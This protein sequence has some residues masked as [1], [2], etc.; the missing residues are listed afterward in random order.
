MYAAIAS[1]VPDAAFALFTGDIVDHAIWNTTQAQNTLDIDDA[2]AR[3]QHSGLPF[4]YGTAG[5]HEAHPVNAFPPSQPLAVY[6][7][8]A[9]DWTP[10]IGGAA[11]ATADRTGSYSVV[12]PGG[13][14]KVISVNTNMYYIDNFWM[15]EDPME[16]D[17]NGQFAWLV[18]EL[19]AAEKAGQRVY[20]IGHMPMGLSDAFHDPS[21]YFDQIVRRYEGTIAAMFFGMLIISPLFRAR[22]TRG[23]MCIQPT[24]PFLT[25]NR[26]SHPPRPFRN[27]LRKL[28]R[29]LL[30]QRPSNILHRPVPNPNIRHALLPRLRR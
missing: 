18:G 14:L 23:I 15:Y 19:D 30:L 5:N 24:T 26:R 17:P 25:K 10:W 29:P 16:R 13:R 27:K 21:N 11:A 8:L 9:R 6:D 20:I 2:Y 28:H 22:K 4:V 12:Y 7:T 1:L 3:M